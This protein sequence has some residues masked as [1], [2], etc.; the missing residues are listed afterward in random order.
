MRSAH[1]LGFDGSQVCFINEDGTRKHCYSGQYQGDFG[2]RNFDTS[3]LNLPKGLEADRRGYMNG[4]A[5]RISK[6]AE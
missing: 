3:N 1:V 5:Y 4:N 2:I 6:S